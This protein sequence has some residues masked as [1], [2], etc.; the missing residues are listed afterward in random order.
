MTN[1][2]P[3]PK[4]RVNRLPKRGHYDRE[5]IY[6]ILDEA[7]ICHVGFAEGGQPFVIPINFARVNDT[8]ILH[9][10]KASRLLKHIEAGNPVCVEATI[11]DGL[12]LARSVFHSSVN[13]R[14]VVLFGTGRLVTDEAEKM[15][16]LEAVV[17]HLI[18][19]RWQEARLPTPKE[20]NATSVVSIQIDEASAKVRLGPP[21]D[22]EEDYALPIWAGVLPIREMPLAPVR[23]EVLPAEIPTPEY[24]KNYSRT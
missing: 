18:P 23:D 24:V 1:F 11:V 9:G 8:I 5:T 15:S 13:Y 12:V 7:L 20:M 4:T 6:Q 21:G 19:G 3:S 16:A 14:S 2:Q 10:A 17:D 22:D